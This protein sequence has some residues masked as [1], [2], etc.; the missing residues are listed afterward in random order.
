VVIKHTHPVQIS[1]G[2]QEIFLRVNEHGKALE[3]SNNAQRMIIEA[4]NWDL[5]IGRF[6]QLY[7]A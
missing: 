1:N 5:I 7:L 3:L 6:H 2:I 4:F